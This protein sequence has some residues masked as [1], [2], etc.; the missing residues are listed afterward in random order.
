MVALG[1]ALRPVLLGLGSPACG[2]RLG[3]MPMGMGLR[4]PALNRITETEFGVK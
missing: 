2:G 3:V 4:T 1:Q